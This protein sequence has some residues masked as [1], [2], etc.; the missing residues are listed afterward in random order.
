M[1]AM[2]PSDLAD[3]FVKYGYV[4][5]AQ[6]FSPETACACRELLWKKL[7]ALHQISRGSP[8]GWPKKIPISE[9]YEESSGDPWK[10]VFTSKL[11]DAIT[12]LSGRNGTERE[13]FGCGWWMITFPEEKDDKTWEVDGKWHIDGHY[14]KHY[15]YSP[16]IGLL[17]IMF[18][19]DVQADG[20]GTALAEGSHLVAAD[21][22]AQRGLKGM[23][24]KDLTQAVIDSGETF[25]I[26]E[27]TGKAGDV[28]IL[29]PFLMHGR[30]SNIGAKGDADRVRF[31]CHPAVPLKKPLKFTSPFNS[32]VD[33]Y[34]L[35]SKMSPLEI[36][37]M[38]GVAGFRS[39]HN[40]REETSIENTNR[41]QLALQTLSYITPEAVREF[42]EKIILR[43]NEAAMALSAEVHGDNI[44]VGAKR[45]YTNNDIVLGGSA[46]SYNY[47]D[48]DDDGH[49]DHGAEDSDRAM[50]ELL[51]FASFK[52][53]KRH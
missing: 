2:P 8:A 36:S 49:D 44:G 34:G 37:M 21:I 46:G 5:V 7:E 19:S 6:A 11:D 25:N 48:D 24:S 22:L 14:F 38:H 27:C 47:V 29:H 35:F 23:M 26:V 33:I 18:F 53:R 9:I 40:M 15:P 50:Q 17:L 51:G 4:K 52:Q 31:M 10:S 45:A 28:V 3:D 41:V 30:S 42:E 20:G 1:T 12:A 32:D 16:E 39:E 13:K 43:A